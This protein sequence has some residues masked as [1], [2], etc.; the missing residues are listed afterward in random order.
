[1]NCMSFES[2]TDLTPESQNKI[3]LVGSHGG[4][5]TGMVAL[6][7]GVRALVCHDAGVGKDQAGIAGLETLQKYGIP[8]ISA[9]HSSAG[10]GLPADMQERGKV[11]HANQCATECG[12]QF[13]PQH[14]L[15]VSCCH[16]GQPN[17]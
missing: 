7:R 6:S 15:R 11:S 4:V 3:V 17:V 13:Q 12:V 16:Q 8:A 1:M 14:R 2:I 9:S 5:A 10:I